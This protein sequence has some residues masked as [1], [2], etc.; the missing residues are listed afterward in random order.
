MKA[1]SFKFLTKWSD[2]T[3]VFAHRILR[4]CSKQGVCLKTLGELLDGL[5]KILSDAGYQLPQKKRW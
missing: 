2:F 5:M 1:V 3:N 4:M